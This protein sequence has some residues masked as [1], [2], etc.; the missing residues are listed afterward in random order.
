[1]LIIVGIIIIILL[2]RIY[3]SSETQR[4]KQDAEALDKSKEEREESAVALYKTILE[5]M[6]L[7]ERHF[8]KYP[9][10]L[11]RLKQTL[12]DCNK[13]I[14]IYSELGIAYS[15]RAR[16]YCKL[17]EY[18]KAWAD[19]RKAERLGMH[20]NPEFINALKQVS[21]SWRG[22]PSVGG[23]SGNNATLYKK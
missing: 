23:T 17:K 3:Q 13:A 20:V 11:D 6:M 10:D 15:N 2:Y 19:V 7:V 1:M 16:V 5:L 8:I 18:D 14:K 21:P 4:K 9:D 12:S 22:I